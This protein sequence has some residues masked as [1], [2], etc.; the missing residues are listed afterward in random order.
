[1]CL[2][3]AIEI[4]FGVYSWTFL[5]TLEVLFFFDFLLN[6]VTVPDEMN[7]P[8][9]KKTA[10]SYLTSYF[11]M[12]FIATIISNILFLPPGYNAGLWAI[13]LKLFRIVRV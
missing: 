2:D 7:N 12:D 1:M 5:V 4:E 10:Y 11:L 9:F 6:F 8:T 3:E 13:R